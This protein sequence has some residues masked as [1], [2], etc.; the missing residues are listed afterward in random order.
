MLGS[1]IALIAAEAVLRVSGIEIV[2]ETVAFDL[3]EYRGSGYGTGE[4]VALDDGFLR[5]WEIDTNGIDEEEV[6]RRVEGED[7]SFHSEATGLEDVDVENF[8]YTGEGNGPGDGLALEALSQLFAFF[9]CN[10]FGIAQAL[11]FTGVWED[12]GGGGY[13]SKQTSPAD[14]IDA[15]RRDKSDR[16]QAGFFSQ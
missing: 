2:E 1:S 11:D 15:G 8:F 3:G 6:G 7:G 16:P 13:G 14:F 10:D 5:D 4:C 9:G 12:H